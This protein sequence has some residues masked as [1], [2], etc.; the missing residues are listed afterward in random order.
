[1]ILL[2]VHNLTDITTYLHDCSDNNVSHTIIRHNIPST[3]LYKT[4]MLADTRRGGGGQVNN[5]LKPYS[6][7]LMKSRFWKKKTNGRMMLKL[8][9][10]FRIYFSFFLLLFTSNR[11]DIHW[12]MQSEHFVVLFHYHPN[13]IWTKTGYLFLYS[14]HENTLKYLQKKYTYNAHHSNIIIIWDWFWV[15]FSKT[16]Y[17]MWQSLLF[18]V[19]KSTARKRGTEEKS[20]K[21]YKTEI[22]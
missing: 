20:L 15:D 4:N 21:Q 17:C 7:I 12:H 22:R 9:I 14:K 18:K 5:R 1:M 16:K 10:I 2:H 3:K 8:I 19:I 11:T 6:V 13:P